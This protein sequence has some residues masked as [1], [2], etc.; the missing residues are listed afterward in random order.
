[1][2]E[3]EAAA[4]FRMEPQQIE[5]LPLDRVVL[6]LAAAVAHSPWVQAALVA[7]KVVDWYF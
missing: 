3:L 7:E 4:E 6:V 2:A 5:I 1:M